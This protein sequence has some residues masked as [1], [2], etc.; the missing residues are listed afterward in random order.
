MLMLVGGYDASSVTV[1]AT[2]A[3]DPAEWIV[4]GTLVFVVQ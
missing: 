3:K 2:F 1:S 4:T